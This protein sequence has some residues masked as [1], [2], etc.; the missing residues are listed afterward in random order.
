MI[1]QI[2]GFTIPALV[3][4]ACVWVILRMQYQREEKKRRWEMQRQSLKEIT[5]LRL[6]AYERLILLL[7]RT[8]PEHLLL[9]VDMNGM[10]PQQLQQQLLRT[11]RL[12]F[13]HNLS[14]QIYVSDELW[15]RIIRARD[16]MEA[17]LNQMAL[18]LPPQ[19][20]ALEYANVLL[21]AYR[22][23]GVTPHQNAQMML[24][25][26]ARQLMES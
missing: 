6:R 9:S 2:I 13:D 23:N 19:S 14:Q 26:E 16:E 17:F 24:R 15:E 1:A 21:S 25:E 18:R 7:E 8:E 12:E 10:T 11:V 3:V 5:Q 20:G 4:F 22:N